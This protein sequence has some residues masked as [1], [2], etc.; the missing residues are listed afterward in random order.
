M[1]GVVILLAFA[2]MISTTTS[3]VFYRL[4]KAAELREQASARDFASLVQQYNRL[5]RDGKEV[6]IFRATPG[7]RVQLFRQKDQS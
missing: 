1:I 6:I 2:C 7:E 3:V 5:R 4:M